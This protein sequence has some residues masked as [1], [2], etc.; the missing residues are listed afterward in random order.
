M[1]KTDPRYGVYMPRF[2]I[3][4]IPTRSKTELRSVLYKLVEQDRHYQISYVHESKENRIEDYEKAA[5]Y[6]TPISQY[7]KLF[8]KQ[9]PKSNE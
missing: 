8:E 3:E 9:P 4:E 5:A 2:T 6:I 1:S 7:L